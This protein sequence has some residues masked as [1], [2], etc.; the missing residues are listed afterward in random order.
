MAATLTTSGST[1][2]GSL[3]TSTVVDGRLAATGY[4]VSISTSGFDLVGAT[5]STA[6]SHIPTASVSAAVT[7]SSGGTPSTTAS[8]TLNASPLFH[9]S[10]GAIS[11]LNLTTTFT[12]SLSVSVPGA[13][14]SG[15]YTGTVTQTVA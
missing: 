5:T 2:S 4:D 13:A 14:G 8:R 10:Y 12:L 1:A 7:A 9:M 3:G 11:L 6:A 15:L